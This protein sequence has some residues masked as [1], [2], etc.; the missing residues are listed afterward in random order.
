VNYLG[1]IKITGWGGASIEG[2]G[3]VLTTKPDQSSEPTR[4]KENCLLKD[5]YTYTVACKHTQY[6]HTTCLKEFKFK[7]KRK[8]N[9]RE[10]VS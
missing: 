9:N 8:T 4:F 10:S 2:A 5:F 7:R 1:R 3:E 6:T